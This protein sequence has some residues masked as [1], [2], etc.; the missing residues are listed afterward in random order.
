MPEHSITAAV[1]SGI[2]P[3]ALSYGIF[4]PYVEMLRHKV[5][6]NAAC[7]PV[8]IGFVAPMMRGEGPEMIPVYL[9]LWSIY[10]AIATV[11][12]HYADRLLTGELLQNR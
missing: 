10:F 7:F 11:L 4:R 8:L 6:L 5:L 3:A 2:L 12:L 1:V 9:G